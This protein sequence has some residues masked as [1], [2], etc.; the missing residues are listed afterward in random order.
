MNATITKPDTKPPVALA[1]QT[2][3]CPICGDP[4][5]NYVALA[6]HTARH[7]DDEDARI[8]REGKTIGRFRNVRVVEVDHDGTLSVLFE[9]SN[10]LDPQTIANAMEYMRKDYATLCAYTKKLTG[11]EPIPEMITSYI[12]ANLE[13]SRE[14]EG[15][16]LYLAVTADFTDG[17]EGFA[18]LN[19]FTE[20]ESAAFRHIALDVF[21]DHFA[22]VFARLTRAA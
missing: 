1:D 8:E 16:D 18:S 9:F 11:G 13:L 12:V 22:K 3:I 7:A 17:Y 15:I 20:E 19:P 10:D 2:F 14:A 21:Q 5:L 4:N 6:E